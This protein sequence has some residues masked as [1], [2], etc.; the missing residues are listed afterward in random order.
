MKQKGTIKL[1]GL[2]KNADLVYVEGKNGIYARLRPKKGS[3][4]NDK[5]LIENSRPTGGKNKLAGKISAIMKQ[6][7]EGFTE[8]N[9]YQEIKDRFFNTKHPSRFVQL[10]ALDGMDAHARN[11]LAK[12]IEPPQ[13]LVKHEDDRIQ[14]KATITRHAKFEKDHKFYS[15]HIILLSW[16]NENDEVSHMHK[17][18]GW[19]DKSKTPPFSYTFEFDRSAKMTEYLVLCCCL[20]GERNEEILFPPDRALG[21]VVVGSFDENA[22]AE[23]TAYRE[24]K[25]MKVKADDSKQIR[26]DENLAQE[27]DEE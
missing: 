26:R 22:L 19:L 18:T 16:N 8:R 24:A 20:R 13:I 4:A 3:H 15:I 14:I 27:P 2:D 17:Y 21:V 1:T 25:K 5:K 11:T 9:L 6:Y 12:S 10:M 7:A 23:L